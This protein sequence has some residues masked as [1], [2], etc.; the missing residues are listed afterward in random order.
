MRLKHL[1]TLIICVTFFSSRAETSFKSI[2]CQLQQ[3]PIR[4]NLAPVGWLIGLVPQVV[5]EKALNAIML[6]YESIIKAGI[7]NVLYLTIDDEHL[8]QIGP[9]PISYY[10]FIDYGTEAG[11]T[12]FWD[13]PNAMPRVIARKLCVDVA[14]DEL[15]AAATAVGIDYPAKIK[16]S[17]IL[18]K[19]S[20]FLMSLICKELIGIAVDKAAAVVLQN[21]EFID[22]VE[23]HADEFRSSCVA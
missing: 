21:E 13:G 9:I 8:A 16:S 7:K 2:R 1:I 3:K 17:S 20:K 15:G 14:Y 22:D 11:W 12:C 23:S 18:L 4:A 10:T 5:L 6:N 19:S